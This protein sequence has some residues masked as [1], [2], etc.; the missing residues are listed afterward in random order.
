VRVA[1][2][3]DQTPGSAILA[4]ADI[5]ANGPEG[6]QHV[7]QF[8]RAIT[9]ALKETSLAGARVYIGGWGSTNKDI[10]DKSVIRFSGM[11]RCARQFYSELCGAKGTRNH[12]EPQ[13][14][15]VTGARVVP[16]GS[17]E[18]RQTRLIRRDLSG[19]WRTK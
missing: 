14:G 1:T 11:R 12:E 10:S 5:D 6:V 4:T 8:P 13:V 9:V 19:T 16:G 17:G 2:Q 3:L 18:Y 15:D 7:E